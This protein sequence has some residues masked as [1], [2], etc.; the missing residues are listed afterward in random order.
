MNELRVG[1]NSPAKSHWSTFTQRR[2]D[3][4]MWILVPFERRWQQQKNTCSRWTLLLRKVWS[5]TRSE[6][7]WFISV[8]VSWG[9]GRMCTLLSSL[10]IKPWKNLFL[11]RTT[12]EAIPVY[13][14]YASFCVPTAL[15]YSIPKRERNEKTKGKNFFWV[16]RNLRIENLL[17]TILLS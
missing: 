13:L 3:E 8:N 10:D 9:V 11:C 1:L 6:F 17:K 2:W 5:R 15:S 14:L 7:M 12:G 4:H 16:F